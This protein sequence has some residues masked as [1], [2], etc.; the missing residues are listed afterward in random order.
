MIKVVATP[1]NGELN[2]EVNDIW[3]NTKVTTSQAFT[4][5]YEAKEPEQTME[6][7]IPPEYHEYLDVFNENMADQYPIS[8]SWD[9]KIEIKPGFE[10]KSFK[11]YNLTPEE[12]EQQKEFINENLKK[13]YIRPSKSPMA[14]PFFFISKKDGK[15]RPTQDYR[16]LNNWT[17]KN[18]YPL[19]LISELMDKV[20]ASGAKY[21][22]KL[23]VRWGFNNVRIKEGDK[24]KATFKM[25]FG[26]Y[27][28]T[29]M[30]FGLC[31]SPATFQSM[32]DSIFED[33]LHEKWIIIYMDD[34]LIFSKTKKGLEEQTRCVLQRLR[35]SNLFLKPKKCFFCLE[36]IE[37]LGMIIEEGKISMDPTK[38]K[39]IRDWPK[40]KTIKQVRSFWVLETFTGDSSENI[41]KLPDR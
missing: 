31:N 7:R 28:P 15:F 40:P 41:Q 37:Y 35:E 4:Q 33:H 34:I 1:L 12:Q 5:K 19:P 18:A 20:Q 32:M 14:S 13:G 27:E 9:H 26:L 23:D 39:G 25:N 6:Q 17:I 30:F 2:N 21:F 22:T 10:P 29:V 8:Q 38:L 16:Y 3:I 11:A 36:K 24:W